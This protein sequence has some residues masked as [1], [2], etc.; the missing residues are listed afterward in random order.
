[1]LPDY[2]KYIW[3]EHFCWPVLLL[4]LAVMS[5]ESQEQGRRPGRSSKPAAMPNGFISCLLESSISPFW[6]IQ[7]TCPW[8]RG[9]FLGYSGTSRRSLSQSCTTGTTQKT[10]DCHQEQ[11]DSSTLNLS[12]PWG[13]YHFHIQEEWNGKFLHINIRNNS[14]TINM[15]VWYIIYK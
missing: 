15:L 5:V 11:K 7:F 2:K 4:H 13:E 9:E 6:E 1:M 12:L 8:V 10:S 14:G 3:Y